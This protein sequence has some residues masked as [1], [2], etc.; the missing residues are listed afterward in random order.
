MLFRSAAIESERRAGDPAVL[1]ADVSKAKSLL[2]WS[3]TRDMDQMVLDTW[4][5]MQ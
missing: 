4:K 1:I 5:S 3:P 2:D